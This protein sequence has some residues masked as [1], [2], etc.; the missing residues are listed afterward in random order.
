MVAPGRK[1]ADNESPQ[2]LYQHCVVTY[3]AMLNDAKAVTIFNEDAE[4]E[5]SIIV[6]EGMLTQFITGQLHLSV[7]YYTFITRAL[8]TMGCIAQLKRGGGTSPSQWQLIKEPNLE[9]FESMHPPR[10]KP[11]GANAGLQNQIN[12]LN[13]RVYVLEGVLATVMKEEADG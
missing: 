5:E 12:D 8:K 9:M 7:P 11:Q 13:R 4:S 6:W 3:K 10:K 1:A 2:A